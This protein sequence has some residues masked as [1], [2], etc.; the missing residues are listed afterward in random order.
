MGLCIE[1]CLIMDGGG[2][3]MNRLHYQISVLLSAVTKR[4]SA[5]AAV[6]YTHYVTSIAC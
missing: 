5:A 1:I 2:Y 6:L 4:I 3:P